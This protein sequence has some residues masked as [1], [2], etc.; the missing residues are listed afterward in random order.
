MKSIRVGTDCSGIEA[1]IQ[2]LKDLNI[3]FIHVFSSEIDKYCVQS[4]DANYKPTIIY[5]DIT[6]RDLMSVPD[7]DLY[8]CG[9]PC[10]PFSQAGLRLGSQEDRGQ[11]IFYCIELIKVKK[12]TY[13]I[14]ENVP[15]LTSIDKGDFFEFILEQLNSIK[16]YNIQWKVLNTK[17][18]G[19]P[20]HRR[21]LFI[22][23]TRKSVFKWP[24]QVKKMRSLKIFVDAS[25]MTSQ[26]IPKSV[27]Q[28]KT[29]ER[30]PKDALFINL[31]FPKDRFPNSNVIAPCLLTSGNLWCVPFHRKANI[32]ECLEL[33]GFPRNFKQVV[34]DTQLKKQI[35]NSMSVCVLKAILANLL[36]T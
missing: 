14:L 26:P 34:S 11:I 6:K 36:N 27:E 33:Q 19:I 12:P 25:D 10:Q 15:G 29:L 4:I 16:G 20:Q 22:V 8:I 31:S 18:F 32:K 2:A 23:G 7:I 3:P 9:F 30:I 24:R 35:G 5:R 17:D 28:N 1:P 21:R 13:F